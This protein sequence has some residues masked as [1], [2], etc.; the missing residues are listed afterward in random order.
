MLQ[1]SSAFSVHNSLERCRNT[2]A[3]QQYSSKENAQA[4]DRN[5]SQESDTGKFNSLWQLFF[6]ASSVLLD[7]AVS[8]EFDNDDILRV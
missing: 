1:S 7:V 3:A 6:P 8:S 2:E 4:W 5:S